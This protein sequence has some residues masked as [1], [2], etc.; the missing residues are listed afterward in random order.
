MAKQADNKAIPDDVSDDVP[1]D[2]VAMSFEA[3]M[4]E[5]ETIVQN[6]EGGQVDLDASIALYSRGA[7]LKRHCEAK[8][9]AASEQVEKIVADGNGQAQKTEPADIQ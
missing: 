3:A 2:I 8:L 9:N 4:T 1:D 6:L 5:L 7:L